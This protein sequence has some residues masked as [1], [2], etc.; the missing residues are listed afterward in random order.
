MTLF[1]LPWFVQTTTGSSTRMGI[2]LAVQ[3]AP[4]ALLGIPSA[5]L[6]SR[7]GSRRTMLL[8]DLG[9]APLLAAVPLLHAAGLLSFALL[10]VL[11]FAIGVFTAPY[12][13]AQRLI[14]PEIVG[15]DEV[16]VARANA[17]LEAGQRATVLVGPS[18]AGVLIAVI[19]NTN[20][21]YLD[22]ASFAASFVLLGLLVPRRAPVARAE[23]SGGLL[24]G[25]RYVRREPMLR[26]L[27]LT[28]LVV[29]AAGQMLFAAVIVL[30][31]Q[32]FDGSS[33]A[34][35]LLIASF[36]GGSVVGALLALRVLERF[37][38]L[39]LGS[40]AFVCMSL[41]IFLLGLDL[42]LA[43]VMAVLAV[44]SFFGPFVNAP[45]IAVITTRTPEAL[46]PK[47]M[48]AIITA[49][50]LAGPAGYLVGGVLIDQ[51]GPRPVFVLVAAIQLSA[52]APFA[53]LA[54]R[55]PGD[56]RPPSGPPR[57][58]A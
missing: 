3:L 57:S 8:G 49:A 2:V 26:V 23:E 29:N 22:A 17:L 34:G 5:A 39:R 31:F 27:A 15:D 1:A 36:G 30:G 53:L 45:L 47:V 51:L 10:L 50:L 7:L 43:A 18:L 33:K 32:E 42:P 21:L 11:V 54:F 20:V 9:R 24:A 6:I 12:W 14:L 13:S 37:D 25:L 28:A 4:I 35:G 40:A 38:P 16:T 46:R 19:G 55:G 44:S 48:T 52:T 56:H 41:P 58:G